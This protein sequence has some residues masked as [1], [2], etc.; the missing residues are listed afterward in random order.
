MSKELIDVLVL[1]DDRIGTT[2]RCPISLKIVFSTAG[3]KADDLGYNEVTF[4]TVLV[5]NCTVWTWPYWPCTK[6]ALSLFYSVY[7]FLWE[8][9]TYFLTITYKLLV[10][11]EACTHVEREGGLPCGNFYEKWNFVHTELSKE[12]TYRYKTKGQ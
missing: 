6:N 7:F 1:G 12:K 9:T 10:R 3:H 2:L 11:K 4:K 5:R 8:P